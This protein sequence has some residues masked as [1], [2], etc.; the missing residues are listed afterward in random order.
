MRR[1]PGREGGASSPLRVSQQMAGSR[2]SCWPTVPCIVTGS[3]APPPSMMISGGGAG[4]CAGLYGDGYRD[5]HGIDL[6]PVVVRR[7]ADTHAHMHGLECEWRTG[8]I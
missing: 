8:R 7:M 5:V 3:A 2:Q 1:G 6:S 4:V